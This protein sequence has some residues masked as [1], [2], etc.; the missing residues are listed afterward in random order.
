MPRHGTENIY[1]NKAEIYEE[2][3]EKR[4]LQFV[5]QYRTPRL[6]TLTEQVRTQFNSVTHVWGSN[7]RYWKLASF[8]YGDS[9]LWWIIAW[10]NEKPTEGHLKIG[11]IVLVP[12]PV[13]KLL[14]FFNYGSV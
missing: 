8:Y 5:R 11:D 6:P 3:F 1:V 4:D 12:K 13:H 9:K 14:S 7:D 10:F 2:F